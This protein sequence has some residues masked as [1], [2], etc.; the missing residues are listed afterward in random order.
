MK[1]ANVPN[2]RCFVKIEFVCRIAQNFD[3]LG[4]VF[5]DRLDHGRD[6]VLVASASQLRFALDQSGYSL[7]IADVDGAEE[8]VTHR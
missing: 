2:A 7:Q 5:V 4:L 6:A 1:P 8:V 3:D